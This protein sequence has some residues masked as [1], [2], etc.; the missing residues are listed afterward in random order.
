MA[1]TPAG[2]LG[3]LPLALGAP[4]GVS[5]PV[6]AAVTL[7][8]VWRGATVRVVETG[9][10]LVVRNPFR[11]YVLPWADVERVVEAESSLLHLDCPAVV[12]NGRTVRLLAMAYWTT[13]FRDRDTEATVRAR[14]AVRRWRAR[15]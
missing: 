3:V 15:T 1:F 12:A 14:A 11:T 8:G 5:V 10:G 9:E 7:Y 2:M 13:A 6:W 4:E